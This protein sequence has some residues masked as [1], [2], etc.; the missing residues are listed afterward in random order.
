[1]PHETGYPDHEDRGVPHGGQLVTA[2][3]ISVGGGISLGPFSVAAYRSVRAIISS[4]GG[5]TV[6]FTWTMAGAAGATET[7]KTATVAAGATESLLYQNQGNEVQVDITGAGNVDYDVRGSNLDPLAVSTPSSAA[8]DWGI[9]RWVP[10]P[11]I[12]GGNSDSDGYAWVTDTTYLGGGYAGATLDA[13][14]FS[15]LVPMYPSG[16]IWGIRFRAAVGPNG[17]KFKVSLATLIEPDPL[18]GGTDDGG[19]ITGTGYGY[20]YVDV[21]GAVTDLYSPGVNKDGISPSQFNWRLNGADGDILTSFSGSDSVTGYPLCDGGGGWYRVKLTTAGKN[22]LSGGYEVKLT[23][24]VVH[25][26][27]DDGFF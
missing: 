8:G 3:S 17:G 11:I 16:S 18:R 7:T 22:G 26:V 5:V 23:A 1:M 13:K 21:T 19:T 15:F 2:S 10:L 14:H 20:S 6:T 12:G 9:G 25:R 27:D 24:V 4:S